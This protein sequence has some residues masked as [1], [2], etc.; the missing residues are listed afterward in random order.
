MCK[1]FY[2]VLFSAVLL[3]V[4]LFS[5]STV[6]AQERTTEETTAEETTLPAADAANRQVE[7]ETDNVTVEREDGRVVVVARGAANR[8]YGD[9]E[10]IV[11]TIP[12]KGRLADTGGSPLIL[13]AGAALLST[14]LLVGRS[15]FRRDP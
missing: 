6:S 8:Q 4:A 9:T 3:V 15:V 2:P 5:A 14:G 12:D 1:S 7:A 11:K 10:V 13:L